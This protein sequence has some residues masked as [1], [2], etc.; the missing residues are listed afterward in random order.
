LYDALLELRDDAVVRLNRAVALAEVSG[1]EVA[2]AE[3]DSLDA[4]AL[5]EFA[6]YHAVRA[7]LLRRLGRHQEA[8]RAY[9]AAL[10]LISTPAEREWMLRRRDSIEG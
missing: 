8:R 3:V 2:L 4:E 10:A 1:V 9:D 5:Q 6:S 7:D